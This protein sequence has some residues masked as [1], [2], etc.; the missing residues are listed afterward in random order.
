MQAEVVE[1]QG[2][3]RLPKG[4]DLLAENIVIAVIVRDGGEGGAVRGKR[5]GR[6][7]RALHFK[8]I[9]HFRGKMLGISCGP[10][11]A[12]A[13]YFAIIK[14]A[15]GHQQTG[16]GDGRRKLFHSA[17][18][19]LYAIGKKHSY[20]V[21]RLHKNIRQCY[22]PNAFLIQQ[23]S[24]TVIPDSAITSNLTAR[25]ARSGRLAMKCNAACQSLSCLL[26]VTLSAAEP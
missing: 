7:A 26:R 23:L 11:I 20:P 1:Q 9:E 14:Q 25:E 18:L 17:M 2:V 8:T 16:C 24:S 15:I 4:P 19:D 13:Q 22:A 3:T 10:A 21:F 5:Y 6:Q 12:T